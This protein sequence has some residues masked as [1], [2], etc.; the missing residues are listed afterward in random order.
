MENVGNLVV[1]LAKPEDAVQIQ[2]I[3]APIVLDTFISFEVDPPQ[4]SE[5]QR[6]IESTLQFYPW[7]VA[8]EDRQILGYAYAGQ[9]RSRQAY[10]WSVDV[11]AYVHTD[12]RRQGIGRK[13]YSALLAILRMQG[14]V[15]AFAG[16]ALP[17]PASVGLHEAVGFT[18]IGVYRQVGYKLGAWHDVGWWGA[19]LN[20]AP[21]NPL[22]PR[23]I[24]E[25]RI[26]IDLD[27]ALSA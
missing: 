1:R 25:I 16:I 7:L 24:A 2:S 22:S 26:E 6:R 13:L 23:S 27:S 17:N 20:D 18:S 10:Q 14:F 21:K 4:V 5:I 8:C 3:Y 19:A 9:H 15:N 12:H 11:S